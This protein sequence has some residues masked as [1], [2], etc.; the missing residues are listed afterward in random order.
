MERVTS[1]KFVKLAAIFLCALVVRLVMAWFSPAYSGMTTGYKGL[2]YMLAAGYGFSRPQIDRWHQL[3]KELARHSEELSWQGLQI[4]SDHHPPVPEDQLRPVFFRMPGFPAFL[5]L[6][7]RLV[8]EPLE[9]HAKTVLAVIG[10]FHPLLV[11]FI[12]LKL[13]HRP[14]VAYFAAW[15]TAIYPP[16][17]QA[18]VFLLPMGLAMGFVLAAVLCWVHGA[19]KGSYLWMVV[20]GVLMAASCYCKSSFMLLWV[21]LAAALLVKQQGWLRPIVSAAILA[22]TLY[23]C[24]L[25]WAV[26]NYQSCGQWMW[27]TSVTGQTI[28]KGIGQYD[29]PWGIRH[30]DP[31]SQRIA[32]EQGFESDLIPEANEYFKQRVK[33]HFKENPGYFFKAALRRLPWILATPF[34]TGYINPYKTKGMFSYYREKEGLWPGQVLL[35]YPG[36]VIRAYWERVLTMVISAAGSLSMLLLIFL[37]WKQRRDVAVFLA[38]PLYLILLHTSTLFCARYLVAMIPFQMMAIGMV[39]SVML[40]RKRARQ[41]SRAGE[42]LR[43]QRADA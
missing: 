5:Y 29:N 14:K 9:L 30:H 34:G 23:A 39:V 18:S 38:L 35:R 12:A 10:S 42:G 4:D 33:E 8:G 22:A 20:A 28:F 17:A 41:A 31:Y 25:P 19:G 7:Y 11:F 24:L 15:A 32:R 26:R 21:F 40:E 6:V 43:P 1:K 3:K 36:Y 27:G 2:A 37:G 16:A 13:F